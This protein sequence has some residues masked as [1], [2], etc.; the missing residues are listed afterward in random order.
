ML[1]GPFTGL[2]LEAMQPQLADYFGAPKGEGLLVQA[3]E[4]GS[5]A[6]SAGIHAAD[7][8]LRADGQ[9]MHSTSDWSKR[10]HGSKGKPMS[11]DVLR[12]H[13]Q[14]T[15]TLEPDSKKH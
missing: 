4:S 13:Q 3:V 12:D 6:A 2:A 15:L 14:I 7:V 9:P 10:L 5:P 8:I 1:H 11:L